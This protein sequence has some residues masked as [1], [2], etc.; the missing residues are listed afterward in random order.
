MAG[1]AHTSRPGWARIASAAIAV[2]LLAVVLLGGRAAVAPDSAS[3]QACS[4]P[5]GLAPTGPGPARFT[6]MLRINTQANVDAYKN[7]S[8][9]TGGLGGRVR[10]Q[11][12]FVLNT[13]FLGNQSGTQPPMTQ[14]VAADLATQLRAAFPC[15]RIIALTGLS[16]DPFSAGFAYTLFDH[17]AVYALLSDWE[18]MDWDQGK[19]T[20]PGRPDWNQ[21]Y[22]VALKRIKGWL[23]GLSGT[24]ASYPTATNKRAGVVPIDDG[25]WNYGE[26]AQAIDKKNRRLGGRHLGPQTVMSQ[27]SCANGGAEGFGARAKEIIEQYKYKFIRK[28]VFRKGKKRKV[29]IRRKLK[30]KARPVLSN[31][32]LQ[33]SFSHTPDPSA[34]M[35]ITKTSAA[36]ADTCISAGLK[37]GGGAFFFFASHEAMALLFQQPRMAG[38]RPALSSS[39]R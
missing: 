20:A 14:T 9:A 15:N 6:M 29:T 22:K 1:V 13:R 26:I 37:K 10:Q 23:G 39:R 7:A 12:I 2:A 5:S 18:P 34:G 27:D 33:I 11:D 28:K 3:A 21:K 24:L 25:S 17:P 31:L 32:G 36:T 35:A 16:F 30:K 8:S 19:A 38:L 4:L